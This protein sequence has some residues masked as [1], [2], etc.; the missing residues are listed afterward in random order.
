MISFLLFIGAVGL[1]VQ[2]LIGLSFFISC[3]W[4][5]ESRAALFAFFQF[6]GMAFVLIVYLLLIRI[7]F[8]RT[9]IGFAILIV[10]YVLAIL[11]AFL[12]LRKT[13]ANPKALKGAEGLIVGE[14]KRQDE[15]EIVF[16]RNRSLRP[17]SEQYEIFYREHPE[18]KETDDARRAKGGP[19]GHPGVIDSPH[20]EA[21]VA[22]L[23]A[24][25]N[26]PFYLSDPKMVNPDPHFY[27]KEKLEGRKT[28]ISPEEATERVKG[29][30]KSIG[31][32]LVGVTELNPLWVYSK[33]GEEMSFEMIGPAPHTPTSIESMHNYS[34]GAYI[35]VQLAAFIA[36]LGYSA[37]ASHL[38]HYESLMVPLAVDAG[39]GELSRMGYLITEELGSRVRLGAVTTDLP[40]I[41][42]KPVDIGVEDFCRFCKKCA[43]CCP[44]QSIPME[45][46]EEVNGTLRWKLNA[47]TCFE[48][49]GKVGTDCNV[50]MRVCPWS[51]ARTFPHRLIVA[52]FYGKRPKPK[53]A[54]KWARF[55]KTE[56]D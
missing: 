50:C 54:P 14:V 17:G 34:K 29:Y 40:L 11:G 12:M 46:Q 6:L 22:M 20:G 31:A 26:M 15:R 41:T 32:R 51:H 44:S 39:L 9:D 5:K 43:V 49:W 23:L 42:D 53:D 1:T 45:D 35:A 10:G 19:M 47:E 30:A 36:N 24:S 13:K 7:G 55:N 16:A 25:N 2:A 27:L 18:Y 56:S 21:N 4:E 28:E 3:I 37:T 38:R 48:Y 8:F 52:I 33:R